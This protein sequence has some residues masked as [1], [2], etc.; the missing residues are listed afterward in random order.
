MADGGRDCT[1]DLPNFLTRGSVLSKWTPLVAFRACITGIVWVNGEKVSPFNGTDKNPTEFYN[2]EPG[3]PRKKNWV[4]VNHID[5]I[6]GDIYKVRFEFA[7]VSK[8]T[9]L[10][11]WYF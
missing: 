9:R 5:K 2:R 7:R 1:S 6:T 10:Y 3:R 11:L 4:F 8:Q